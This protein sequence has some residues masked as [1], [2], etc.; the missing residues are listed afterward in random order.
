M[1]I[2]S[3]KY[4]QLQE[5][6]C[7]LIVTEPRKELVDPPEHRADNYAEYT[8]LFFLPAIDRNSISQGIQRTGR[9]S[10]RPS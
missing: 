8:V 4:L 1:P 10:W 3:N 9:R 2:L 7:E 5:L 6:S